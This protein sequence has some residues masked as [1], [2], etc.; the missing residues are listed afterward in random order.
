MGCSYY[1][2]DLVSTFINEVFQLEVYEMKDVVFFPTQVYG[3]PKFYAWV[4]GGGFPRS[5]EMTSCMFH[6]LIFP[7]LLTETL[8]NQQGIDVSMAYVGLA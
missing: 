3:S 2:C 6:P 5:V 1:Y 8:P 7:L 4:S